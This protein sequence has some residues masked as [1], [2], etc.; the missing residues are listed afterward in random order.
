MLVDELW[1]ASVSDI[2][3]VASC[4]GRADREGN[5]WSSGHVEKL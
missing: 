4:I 1:V 3:R 5:S 2:G